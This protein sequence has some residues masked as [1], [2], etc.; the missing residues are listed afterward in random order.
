MSDTTPNGTVPDFNSPSNTPDGTA[1]AQQRISSLEK[2]LS[3]RTSFKDKQINARDAILKKEYAQD[4]SK[5]HSI[6]DDEMRN[7]LVK[8]V[9]PEYTDSKDPYEDARSNGKLISQ[10]EV[11]EQAKTEK[12]KAMLA[13]AKE[14]EPEILEKEDEFWNNYDATNPRLSEDERY[15]LAM[16]LTKGYTSPVIRQEQTP[17]QT[18][19]QSNP[20]PQAPVSNPNVTIDKKELLKSLAFN[21]LAKK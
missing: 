18:P 21:P 16:K 7:H 4:P 19:V 14:Y 1:E 2:Q 11:Q 10:T 12:V 3:D 6:D 5:I 17:Y 8:I 15:K 20:A 13:V 9:F